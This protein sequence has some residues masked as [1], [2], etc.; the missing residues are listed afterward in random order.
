M[1][2]GSKSTG[3]I[4]LYEVACCA[5]Y[6]DAR[7]YLSVLSDRMLLGSSVHSGCL[8]LL[9]ASSP[10][11]PCGYSL[12][13]SPRLASFSMCEQQRH[14]GVLNGSHMNVWECNT[15]AVGARLGSHRAVVGLPPRM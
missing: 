14:T 7:E 11:I 9:G 1:I 13:G 3:H 4:W 8:S 15:S 5:L 10:R 12:V 6:A 2:G